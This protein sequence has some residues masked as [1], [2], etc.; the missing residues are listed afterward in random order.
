MQSACQRY[1]TLFPLGLKRFEAVARGVWLWVIT[2][3]CV[4]WRTSKKAR[5]FEGLSTC[6]GE[7]HPKQ[8]RNGFGV[9]RPSA[10]FAATS[11]GL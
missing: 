11:A 6:Q 7:T 1:K 3:E 5:H 9:Q 2:R 10:H 8:D 4:Q